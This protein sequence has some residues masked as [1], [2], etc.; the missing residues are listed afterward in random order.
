MLLTGWLNKIPVAMKYMEEC[1]KQLL[2]GKPFITPMGRKR[3]Y[4]LITGDQE[5][6][7]ESRN[8]EV[9]STASDLTLLSAID[10]EDKLDKLDS[11]I[12]NII[13][14]SIIIEAP[15]NKEKVEKIFNLIYSTMENMP[16]KWL[17]TDI[18][19]TC[20]ISYGFKWGEMIKFEKV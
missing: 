9:Q 4:G 6:K 8:F 11:F 7:N 16:K 10:M 20:N 19:F 17:N 14:D 5:Q 2:S 18:P 1:E 15:N 3:R 12:V 13:H